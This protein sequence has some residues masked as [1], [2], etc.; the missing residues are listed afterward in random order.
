MDTGPITPI[1]GTAPNVTPPSAPQSSKFDQEKLKKVCVEIESL[2]ISQLLQFMRRTV[3]QGG[4]WGKGPGKDI[5]ETLF[6]Q[7]L[8]KSLAKRGGLGLG[9]LVYKQMIKGEEKMIPR[10]QELKTLPRNGQKIDED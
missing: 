10:A 2:F 4:L 8:S 7:E 9:N 6:D 1:G 3:P 5:Y